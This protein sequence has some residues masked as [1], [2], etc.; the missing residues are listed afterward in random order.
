MHRL[1]LSVLNSK[2]GDGVSCSKT[3]RYRS[4]KYN[5]NAYFHAAYVVQ[6]DARYLQE[7]GPLGRIHC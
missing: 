7:L 3:Q 6:L 2:G 5:A 4:A 1:G